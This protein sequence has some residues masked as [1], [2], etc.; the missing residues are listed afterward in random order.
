MT[1]KYKVGDK[2][3]LRLTDITYEELNVIIERGKDIGEIVRIDDREMNAYYG[4]VG[5]FVK[6]EKL[7]FT[8]YSGEY[9]LQLVEKK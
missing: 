9:F 7:P 8:V 3:Q 2:V 4:Q 5:Y 1:A 6:F